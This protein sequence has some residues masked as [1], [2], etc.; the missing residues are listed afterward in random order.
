MSKC[1]IA[2]G[3]NL[4]NRQHNLDEAV[5]QLLA[6]ENIHFLARSRPITTNPIGGPTG[7]DSFLNEVLMIETNP[8]T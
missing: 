6:H 5:N 3:S 2:L 8:D 4:G 7:Q 1:L